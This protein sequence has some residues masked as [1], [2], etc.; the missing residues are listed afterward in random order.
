MKSISK[1]LCAAL[2]CLG[3]AGP[4]AAIPIANSITEYS[5]VQGQ[6]SW[7]YGF[8]NLTAK[9]GAYTSADFFMAAARNGTSNCSHKFSMAATRSIQACGAGA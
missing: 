9:G 5:A 7:S 3:C 8:F 6:D 2:A 4:A 1:I